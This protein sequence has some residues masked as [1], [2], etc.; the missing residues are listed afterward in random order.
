MKSFIGLGIRFTKLDVP[1]ITNDIEI[2]VLFSASFEKDIV[3]ATEIKEQ[4]LHF[5]NIYHFERI[6][7]VMEATSLYSFHPAMFFMK[8]LS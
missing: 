7:I 8:I 4:V 2:K 6:V 1:I 5:N 3:G